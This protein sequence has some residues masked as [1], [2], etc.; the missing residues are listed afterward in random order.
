MCRMKMLYFKVPST[1]ILSLKHK[2][3]SQIYKLK[4]KIIMNS[5]MSSKM[6]PIHVFHRPMTLTNLKMK[7]AHFRMG[8][9]FKR[10]ISSS[11]YKH[12]HLC[13]TIWICIM[14]VKLAVE[15]FF[16]PF[17]G[18]RNSMHSIYWGEFDTNLLR[19]SK[20]LSTYFFLLF[21]FKDTNAITS[22]LLDWTVLH[23]LRS[24]I[25][26]S[27]T[28]HRYQLIV[29]HYRRCNN[30]RQNATEQIETTFRTYLEDKW[31]LSRDQQDEFGWF[32]IR[33]SKIHRPFQSR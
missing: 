22:K 12:R 25:A 23:W 20:L 18:S 3:S 14:C 17:A 26:F 13:R 30:S 31:L 4:D 33:F 15:F 32:W 29:K 21:Q 6:I 28:A 19:R 9:C 1:K 5:A 7:W 8:Q 16:C 2:K 11:I 10:E 24:V 27:I